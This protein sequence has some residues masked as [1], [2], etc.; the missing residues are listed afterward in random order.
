[1]TLLAVASFAGAAGTCGTLANDFILQGYGGKDMISIDGLPPAGTS[2]YGNYNGA[3]DESTFNMIYTKGCNSSTAIYLQ[4][5]VG[6]VISAGNRA[7][8]CAIYGSGN[9]VLLKKSGTTDS[10]TTSGFARVL[11]Y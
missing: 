8:A 1:M 5:T 9:S 3:G 6:L 2:I 11:T 10:G 4:S 7:S